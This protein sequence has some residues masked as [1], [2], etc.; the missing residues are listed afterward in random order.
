MT[1]KDHKEI[2]RVIHETLE[3]SYGLEASKPMSIETT[4]C[5]A[6]ILRKLTD[7]MCHML[8]ADNTRFDPIMFRTAALGER[9]K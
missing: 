8:L 1:S 3:Y 4:V 2:A 5:M 9:I 7:T 6:G